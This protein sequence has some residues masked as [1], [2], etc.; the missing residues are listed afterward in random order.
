MEAQELIRKWKLNKGFL[1]SKMNML[2][3]TFSNK[4]SPNHPTQFKHGEKIQL[5]DLL[6]EMSKELAEI[7]PVDFE[8]TMQSLI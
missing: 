6:I 2:K 4:L 3:G 1:A 5:R 7:N 8:K